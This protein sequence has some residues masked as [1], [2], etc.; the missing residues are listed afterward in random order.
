[1]YQSPLVLVELPIIKSQEVA[2]N[3][4]LQEVANNMSNLTTIGLY[5]CK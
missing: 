3:D 2:R 4:Q 5:M 1:M